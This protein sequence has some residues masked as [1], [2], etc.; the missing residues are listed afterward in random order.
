VAR[1]NQGV[2][3]DFVVEVAGTPAADFGWHLVSEQL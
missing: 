1:S 2:R 3:M